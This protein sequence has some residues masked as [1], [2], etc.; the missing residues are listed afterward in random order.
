MQ[1][2]TETASVGKSARESVVTPAL[3]RP[4]R[5][6]TT[7]TTDPPAGQAPFT[8][9]PPWAGGESPL[10]TLRKTP[11][12]DPC[13]SR[14]RAGNQR[15]QSGIEPTTPQGLQVAL[16]RPAERRSRGATANAAG[17]RQQRSLQR[18]PACSNRG[19]PGGGPAE[20]QRKAGTQ[21]VPT[22]PNP[23]RLAGPRKGLS[24]D[25]LLRR[26][27]MDV[28]GRKPREKAHSR[29]SGATSDPS[30][31]IPG[32]GV[33]YTCPPGKA[34]REK[35]PIVSQKLTTGAPDRGRRREFMPVALGGP[36]AAEI[37]QAG[38]YRPPGDPSEKAPKH[39]R[40]GAYTPAANS[41]I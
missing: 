33:G 24:M 3:V 11:S 27:S 8:K 9:L 16:R 17:N 4:A 5:Q 40:R 19:N 41:P 25:G 30:Q 15:Q 7:D 37:R 1:G 38:H 20:K 29:R 26:L 31:R 14:A 13:G 35:A 10:F 39:A 6:V 2:L 22:Q 12:P 21:A 36:W 32:P 18:P 23:H 34:A 28:R